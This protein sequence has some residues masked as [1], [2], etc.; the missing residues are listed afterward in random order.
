MNGI[1]DLADAM[2]VVAHAVDACHP[3]MLREEIERFHKMIDEMKKSK[4]SL[5]YHIGSDIKVNGQNI[6]HEIQ[7]ARV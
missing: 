3:K 4:V 7:D 5:I 1:G 6:W 2:Q